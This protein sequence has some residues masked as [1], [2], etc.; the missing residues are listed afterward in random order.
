MTSC[1]NYIVHSS[2]NLH[3]NTQSC[4]R[5]FR[6]SKDI[7]WHFITLS[8]NPPKLGLEWGMKHGLFLEAKEKVNTNMYIYFF[9]EVH[10]QINK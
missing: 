2:S 8:L 4:R 9:S 10:N 6:W 1:Q 3:C 7:G 5:G